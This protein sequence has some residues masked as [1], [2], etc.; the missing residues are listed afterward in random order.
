MKRQITNQELLDLLNDV[1]GYIEY[2]KVAIDAENGCRTL[3][4]L[5]AEREMPAIYENVCE[6]IDNLTQ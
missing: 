5:I 6:M 1:K 3:E 4:Q 2:S